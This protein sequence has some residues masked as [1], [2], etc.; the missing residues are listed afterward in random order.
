MRLAVIQRQVDRIQ[1]IHRP[2]HHPIGVAENIGGAIEQHRPGLD[3]IGAV[4]VGDM[5]FHQRGQVALRR[6]PGAG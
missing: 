5:P 4:I 2:L 1:H 3:V 6:P